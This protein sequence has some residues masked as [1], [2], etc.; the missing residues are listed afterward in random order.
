MKKNSNNLNASLTIEASFIFPFILI[1]FMIII[2]SCLTL[3]DKVVANSICYR[4]II[5]NSCKLSDSNVYDNDYY[6]N[7]FSYDEND[8]K[9]AVLHSLLSKS[10]YNKIN[11]NND[12]NLIFNPCEN[13]RKLH[14]LKTL[15]N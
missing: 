1:I 11:I 13:K 12:L 2:T 10:N 15:I 14:F 4:Y 9:D 3:H 7:N 5:Y 6:G 8:L